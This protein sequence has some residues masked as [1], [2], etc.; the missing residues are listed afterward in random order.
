[1]LAVS[2][3]VDNVPTSVII[4]QASKLFPLVYRALS[5]KETQMILASLKT[6]H[7]LLQHAQSYMQD[8][9]NAFLPRVLE[10]TRLQESMVSLCE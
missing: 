2:H 8:Q 6:L 4:N 7:T 9:L 5:S 10:L 1:M 3:L